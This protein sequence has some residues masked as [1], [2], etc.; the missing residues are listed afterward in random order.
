MMFSN[1]RIATRL[2]L[3]GAFFVLA[4]LVVA[5]GGW[6]ALNDAGARGTLAMAR[7]ARLT[8]AVDGAR[9][10]QVQFK[11]Q[12]Q[13]WK[14][15]LLRGG[16]PAQFDKYSAAFKNSAAATTAKLRQVD[17]ILAELGIPS[18]LV[19]QALQTH[20]ELGAKYL[21]A[22]ATY[23]RANPD[24]YKLVDAQVKGMDRAPTKKIDDIVQLIAARADALGQQVRQEQELAMHAAL[25]RLGALVVLTLAVGGALMLWL[26]RSISAPLAQAVRIARTVASGDLSSQIEADGADEIGELLRTLKHMHDNLAGIVA[27]VRA[28]TDAIAGASAAIAAGNHDLS[29]RTEAQAGSLEQTASAIEALT[30]TLRENGGNASEAR[31]L[32]GTASNVAERGGAAVAQVVSTM[33][34]INAASRKIVDIIGVI[35]GIAFQTNI[36]ALNAAVEAARAGEQGRGFAVVASEVRNLAQRSAAAAKEIK[37][38]IGNSVEQ[39]DAGSKLVGQAGGTMEEMLASVGKVSDMVAGIALA[40]DTQSAGIGQINQAI[41]DMDA[42][43][44]QNAVLVQQSAAAADALHEQAALLAQ[45]V[46]VFKIRAEA[47]PAA[48]RARPARPVAPS[49]A[50]PLDWEAL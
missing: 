31:A 2:A 4:L 34:S 16:D 11:I 44:R 25:V 49:Q 20:E 41:L 33:G 48:P 6:R 14:D 45:A 40:S 24:S 1:L 21:A 38:L 22:L 7:A 37:T 12:V 18:P 42:M 35:D 43:T 29:A 32:A 8:Q 15:I 47:A 19:A 9:S 30:T 28:G 23:D 13:E 10:A 46:S 17:A 3:L 27:K 39:V 36:L 50:A 26:A 5:L